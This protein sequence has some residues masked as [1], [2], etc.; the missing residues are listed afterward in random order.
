MKKVY[1][2][3]DTA[4]GAYVNFKQLI[5]AYKGTVEIVLITDLAKLEEVAADDEPHVFVFANLPKIYS[6]TTY[7][8][9]DIAAIIKGHNNK[10]G[11]IQFSILKFPTI[12]IDAHCYDGYIRGNTD[13]EMKDA[14]QKHFT[15][16]I[17]GDAFDAAILFLELE[18]F[19]VNI[20]PIQFVQ[21]IEQSILAKYAFVGKR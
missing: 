8:I 12:Y 9:E 1:L 5:A 6:N 18:A 13:I 11:I 3:T 21:Q 14:L 7:S 19:N 17:E 10:H 2:I 4:R 15:G 20:D 16:I